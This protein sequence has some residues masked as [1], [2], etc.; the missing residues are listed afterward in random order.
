MT[1]IKKNNI[2]KSGV[3]ENSRSLSISAEEKQKEV[4]V[5]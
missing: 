5:W 1:N 3:R 4:N 2:F